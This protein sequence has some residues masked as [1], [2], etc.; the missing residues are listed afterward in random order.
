MEV[1]FDAVE[2][3]LSPVSD[4]AFNAFY[5]ST[6]KVMPTYIRMRCVYLCVCLCVCIFPEFHLMPEV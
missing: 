6:D 4:R 1:G 2:G 3:T 5:E